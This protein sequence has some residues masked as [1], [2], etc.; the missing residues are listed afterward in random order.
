MEKM[1]IKSE[2]KF[3]RLCGQKSHT[4]VVFVDEQIDKNIFVFISTNLFSTNIILA[5]YDFP[6]NKN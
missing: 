2:T 1:K 5:V 3:V 4:L 6:I